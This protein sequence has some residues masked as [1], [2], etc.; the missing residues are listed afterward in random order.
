MVSRRRVLQASVLAAVA[1]WFPSALAAPV[2][3]G[4]LAPRQATTLMPMLRKAFA[5]LGYREPHTVI[6]DFR[7][8]DDDLARLPRLARSLT[9][10]GCDLLIALGSEATAKALREA[11]TRAPV[12]FIAV[13][14]DPVDRGVV[15]SLGRP[16]GNL[17]GVYFPTP[18]LSAKRLEIAVEVLP[19]AKRFL[20]IGDA[21]TKDQLGA[22]R[23]AAEAKQVELIVF[24]YSRTPYDL[25]HAFEAGKR[26]GAEAL[27]VLSSGPLVQSQA[28]LSRQIVA[29]RLPA[30]VPAVGVDTSASLIRYS[31][32]VAK[33]VHRA[34]QM[35]VML[36]GGRDPA[37][38]PVEGPHEFLL[39]V[40]MQRAKQLGITIPVSVLAR[41]NSVME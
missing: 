10:A 38:M 24:E 40:N 32:D 41:A 4:V 7:S 25:A 19:D 36:L 12:L 5:E 18:T 13:G 20:A 33:T 14:Y 27:I 8:A 31:F 28:E 6:F 22:V 26:Q 21:Y 34:A 1:R 35:G 2:R 9:E 3:V 37:D 15:Q 11:A 30:F 23:R 16:G 39:A 29:N 17:T